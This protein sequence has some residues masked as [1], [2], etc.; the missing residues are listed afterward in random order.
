VSA[1]QIVRHRV[2]EGTGGDYGGSTWYFAG[3]NGDLRGTARYCARSDS[4]EIGSEPITSPPSASASTPPDAAPASGAV[5]ENALAS[6]PARLRSDRVEAWRR[7]RDGPRDAW[8]CHKHDDPSVRGPGAAVGGGTPDAPLRANPGGRRDQR[9]TQFPG[10]NPLI[11]LYGS[12]LDD[13]IP[14]R[15]V[16]FRD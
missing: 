7:D 10:H 11:T 9:E 6:L 2:A 1:E 5:R 12:L 16:R 8:T 14:S 13:L 4:K 15:S 3:A